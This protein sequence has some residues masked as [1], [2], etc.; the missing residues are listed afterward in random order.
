M[1]RQ[2]KIQSIIPSKRERYEIKIYMLCESHTGY[3]S[4][5]IVYTGADTVY[6]EPRIILPKLCEDYSNPLKI[7]LSLLEGFYNAGDNLSLHDLYALPELLRVL[8]ENKNDAYET[9][10]KKRACR[11]IFR[12]GSQQKE[13]SS[14]QK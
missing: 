7:V 9:L 6:P 11:K 1:E 14:L 10:Q 3:L 8:F 12:H 2:A 4:D 13:L 5:F